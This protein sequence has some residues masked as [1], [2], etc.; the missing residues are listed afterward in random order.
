MSPTSEST[1]IAHVDDGRCAD[2]ALGLMPRAERAA[3]LAHLGACAVCEARLRAHVA[4]GER[5]RAEALR[6][7]A[8]GWHA[9]EPAIAPGRGRAAAPPFSHWLPLAAVAVL[10]VVAVLA[11]VGQQSA[12]R[13]AA[14]LPAPG[15]AVRTRESTGDDP[16]FAAGLDAYR[17]RD[18][19]KAA[20][21]LA[22]AR[23]TG[24]AE[25]MRRL[26]LADVRLRRGDGQGAFALLATVDWYSVPEPWRRAGAAVLSRA[27][28]ATGREASADSI[29]RNLEG[30]S[31]GIP[32]LP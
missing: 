15:E 12:D 5:A 13:G 23:T 28:H 25:Q 11:I 4:A 1:G 31:P 3:A 14:L 24:P 20:R 17:A 16:H 19:A 8:E 2:L 27:L 6:L 29:D 30:T 18:L 32:F 7:A 26:Y 10:A 9:G 21:E 22:A